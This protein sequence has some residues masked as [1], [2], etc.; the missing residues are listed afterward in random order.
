M[1]STDAAVSAHAVDA[2]DVKRFL[3][4]N[5]EE[6][7]EGEE[8]RVKKPWKLGEEAL[9]TWKAKWA[10]KAEGWLDEGHNLS[11]MREALGGYDM[12]RKNAMKYYQFVKKYNERHPGRD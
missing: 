9:N 5:H 6:D 1:T 8:E 7:E 10:A 3:R 4:S 11:S 2:S 12:S